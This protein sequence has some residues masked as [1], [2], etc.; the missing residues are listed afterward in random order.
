MFAIVVKAECPDCT[1][2]LF[3][4]SVAQPLILQTADGCDPATSPEHVASRF[5]VGPLHGFPAPRYRVSMEAHIVVDELAQHD[6]GSINLKTIPSEPAFNSL[7]FVSRLTIDG[8]MKE[9]ALAPG[10]I[11][12]GV[13]AC[14]ELFGPGCSAKNFRE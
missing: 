1:V 2:T 3:G 9:R 5:T 11:G 12:E 14:V 7:E 10:V 13:S 8:A 6:S 4:V